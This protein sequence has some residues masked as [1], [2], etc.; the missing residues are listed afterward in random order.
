ML[1]LQGCASKSGTGKLPPTPPDPPDKDFAATI[2]STKHPLV[3]RITV[4]LVNPKADKGIGPAPAF[5]DVVLESTNGAVFA[6]KPLTQTYV[7]E[8]DWAFSSEDRKPGLKTLSGRVRLLKS[9]LPKGQYTLR[10]VVRVVETGK[11]ALHGPHTDFGSVAVPAGNSVKV[12]V[13]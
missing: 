4:K 12:T 10:P 11:D 8:V 6:G 2:S 13:D 5:V 9:K 1:L 7:E 3:F